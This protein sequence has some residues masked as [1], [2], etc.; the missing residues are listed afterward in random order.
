LRCG[1]IRRG[2]VPTSNERPQWT[3]WTVSRLSH[4]SRTRARG[5][6]DDEG[7]ARRLHRSP[8]AFKC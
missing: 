5:T 8:L 2:S 3:D 1:R 6:V 4:V 7:L